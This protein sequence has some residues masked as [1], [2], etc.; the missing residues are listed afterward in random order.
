MISV[1]AFSFR[2]NRRAL[3][4]FR[5]LGGLGGA[6][7]FS[8]FKLDSEQKLIGGDIQFLRHTITDLWNRSK[9]QRTFGRPH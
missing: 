4:N 3:L 7:T 1:I 8:S 6:S 2:R 5:L 9:G